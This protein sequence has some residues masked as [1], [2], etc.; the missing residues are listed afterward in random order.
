MIVI[1]E[2]KIENP[3][4][5]LKEAKADLKAVREN[6]MRKLRKRKSEG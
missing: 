2:A 4:V 3:D 6:R 5:K 1:P